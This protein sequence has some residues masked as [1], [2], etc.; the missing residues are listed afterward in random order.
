MQCTTGKRREVFDCPSLYKLF[1]SHW[2]ALSIVLKHNLKAKCFVGGCKVR[3]SSVKIT[4]IMERRMHWFVVSEEIR[5]ES[6]ISNA[7][8]AR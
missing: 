3:T 1:C 7:T 4:E 5:I 6:S 2:P 8:V